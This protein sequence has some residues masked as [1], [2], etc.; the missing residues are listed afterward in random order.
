MSIRAKTLLGMLAFFLGNLLLLGVY[1]QFFLRGEVA[2]NLQAAQA[3]V[4]QTTRLAAQRLEQAPEG[5]LGT[6][7]GAEEFGHFDFVV[8]DGATGAVLY[9]SHRRTGDL[10][11][12]STAVARVGSRLLVV[13]ATRYFQLGTVRALSMVQQLLYAELIIVAALLAGLAVVLQRGFLRPLG[14]LN[15]RMQAYRQGRVEPRPARGRP[16]RDELGQLSREFDRLTDALG[17]E[18][19]LQG[20]IIA[21][22]SHDIKT[23]LTSV[24]G[25]VERLLKG[26]TRDEERT[27]QYLQTIYDRAQSINEIVAEFDGYLASTT[28]PLRLQPL[29]A[30]HLCGLLREEYQEELGAAG[31]ALTVENRAGDSAVLADMGKLRRVF[32]NLIANAVKHAAPVGPLAIA[33][34]CEQAGDRLRMTVGDNGTGVPVEE[35]ERIFEPFFTRNPSRG[36]SSGL[37]LSICRGLVE[38]HGGTVRAEVPPQGGLAIVLELP[39]A[40]RA[41]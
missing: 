11:F 39:L 8:T 25:Y 6:F 35:L 29:P 19:R 30:S 13:E 1:Y 21:S 36:G 3:Q 41:R 16:R 17:E 26:G 27:R 22:I 14:E 24:M 2:G 38:A 9:Q 4:E 31:V 37:G 34:V 12:H 40:D 7:L 32:G 18:K 28:Q 20:R 23:P 15:R 5:D 33:I 10:E